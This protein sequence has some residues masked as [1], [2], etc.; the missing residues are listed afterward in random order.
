MSF[1]HF[2]ST[3][4]LIMQN[5]KSQNWFLKRISGPSKIK[6]QKVLL[7]KLQKE[8]FLKRRLFAYSLWS[9]IISG[10]S[11]MCSHFFS[12]Q[13]WSAVF[14]QISLSFSLWENC[15]FF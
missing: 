6:T 14:D 15:P 4:E 7:I 13:A 12:W 9:C 8:S 2:L 3:V 11:E 5:I 1:C 10:V